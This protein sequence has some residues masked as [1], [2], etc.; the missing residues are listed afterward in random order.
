MVR[1]TSK[2]TPEMEALTDILDIQAPCKRAVAIQTTIERIYFVTEHVSSHK[3][4]LSASRVVEERRAWPHDLPACPMLTHRLPA[5]AERRYTRRRH[6]RHRVPPL[7][8]P[9]PGAACWRAV[10]QSSFLLRP[11]ERTESGQRSVRARRPIGLIIRAPGRPG[12]IIMPA[13]FP[14]IHPVRHTPSGCWLPGS[15]AELP[16]TCCGGLATRREPPACHIQSTDR[17][18]RPMQLPPLLDGRRPVQPLRRRRPPGTTPHAGLRVHEVDGAAGGAAG[19]P[20]VFKGQRGDA[21]RVLPECRCRGPG[22]CA[23]VVAH[24]LAVAATCSNM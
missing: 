1:E 22:R 14:L 11:P 5:A 9:A 23:Q 20:G 10:L 18:P 7:L 19:Q 21:A 17:A 16:C 12:L 13:R 15:L 2:C 8:I 3:R 4:L 24:Q 6:K